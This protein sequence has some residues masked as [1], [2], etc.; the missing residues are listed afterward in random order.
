MGFREEMN[1]TYYGGNTHYSGYTS[2]SAD[3][4]GFSLG[5]VNGK[6]ITSA[7]VNGKSITSTPDPRHQITTKSTLTIKLAIKNVIY[8]DPA[9]IIYWE[10]GTKTVV[11]ANDEPFDREKG[12]SMAVLK[13]LM[14]NQGSYFNEVKR[15]TK[16]GDTK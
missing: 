3:T 12:F 15:W 13:K 10:D 5:F 1:S 14:G 16:D 8:N 4:R 2:Y 6:G 11:K 9:T 7:P